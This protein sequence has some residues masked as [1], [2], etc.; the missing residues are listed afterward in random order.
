MIKF[1]VFL[2]LFFFGVINNS[3]A[4]L[5]PGT[6]GFIIQ[7]VI[8]FFATVFIFLNNIRYKLKN[9]FIKLIK[10]LSE[11]KNKKN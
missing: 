3:Y 8:A 4:Y 7:M 5:D 11:H 2:N 6:G 1:L 10:S 9:I